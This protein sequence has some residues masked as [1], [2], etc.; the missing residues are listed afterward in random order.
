MLVISDTSSPRQFM[1]SF[2]HEIRH[3]ESHIEQA[4]DIDPYSEEAAYLAG[5]IGFL[6]FPAVR[7]FFCEHC[8]KGLYKYDN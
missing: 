4:Y 8:R 7:K 2:I 5:H 6:M 1:D 3:L